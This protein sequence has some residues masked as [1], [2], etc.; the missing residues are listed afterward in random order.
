[1]HTSY[2][3]FE[4]YVT[5]FVLKYVINE[6]RAAILNTQERIKTSTEQISKGIYHLKFFITFF[7]PSCRLGALLEVHSEVMILMSK[8]SRMF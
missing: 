5:V 8:K 4:C 1:M 2:K 3:M 7:V 6:V